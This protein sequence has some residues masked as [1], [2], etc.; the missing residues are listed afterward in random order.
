MKREANLVN[1]QMKFKIFFIPIII[2]LLCV[3]NV[4][5]AQESRSCIS[6]GLAIGEPTSAVGRWYMNP[7]QA[8]EATLG[9]TLVRPLWNLDSEK[10]YGEKI[11]FNI[12]LSYIYNL[13][14]TRKWNFPLYLGV[15]LNIRFESSSVTTFGI[16]FPTI[17]IEYMFRAKALKIGICF[18][19]SIVTNLLPAGQ[20]VVDWITAVFRSDPNTLKYFYDAFDLQFSLGIRFYI[21]I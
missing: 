21:P 19:T 20:N 8:L 2:V 9:V 3:P 12:G 11:K 15:G 18:E 5:F 4:L 17:G 6:L 16:K 10:S 7:N 13:F 14:L 1:K